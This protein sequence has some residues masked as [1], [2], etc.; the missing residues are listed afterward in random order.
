[1]TTAREQMFEPLWQAYRVSTGQTALPYDVTTPITHAWL[2]SYRDWG[3]PIT[4]PTD[5]GGGYTVQTFTRAVVSW[6]A[7]AG[8]SVE[9]GAG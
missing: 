5:I 1:M 3:S 7:A 8:I 6:N 9:T 4:A 2:E